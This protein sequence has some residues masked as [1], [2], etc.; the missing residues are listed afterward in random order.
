MVYPRPVW[1]KAPGARFPGAGCTIMET[2]IVIRVYLDVCCLNR[3]FDDQRQDR[4]RLEAEAVARIVERL[5]VGEWTWVGSEV[6]RLEIGKIPDPVRKARVA[7]L[8]ASTHFEIAVESAVAARAA[9]LCAA[10]FGNM[11][12]L[13]L[14]CAEAGQADVFLTTDDK[15]L[16]LAGRCTDLLTVRVEN[17]LTWL[18]EV[19]Q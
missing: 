7:L 4:I 13:H 6:M 19:A 3:P 14:A 2:F 12:A 11:D 17:P 9:R 8:G 10:G 1:R 5:S 15:L 16:R 18:E